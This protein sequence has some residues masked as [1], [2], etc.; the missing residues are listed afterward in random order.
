MVVELAQTLTA[1]TVL[2]FGGSH[3]SVQV[4]GNISINGYPSAD[5]TIY[6]DLDE[7]LSVGAAS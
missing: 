1:G 2:T 3:K 4:L 7:P 5:K 6:F